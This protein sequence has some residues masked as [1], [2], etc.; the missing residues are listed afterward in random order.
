MLSEGGENPHK[1]GRAAKPPAHSLSPPPLFSQRASVV[2]FLS[3]SAVSLCVEPRPKATRLRRFIRRLH[4]ASC[5]APR[6]C[7][8]TSQAALAS[9]RSGNWVI[10]S[11]GLFSL[12]PPLG[13]VH[14]TTRMCFA[15]GAH[16]LPFHLLLNLLSH[17]LLSCFHFPSV[18]TSTV[19]I[20]ALYILRSLEVQ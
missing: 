15:C 1:A 6:L 10:N 12:A 20:G 19:P 7:I 18:S 16:S 13:G 2:A 3:P 5:I 11:S 17:I 4:E 14:A 9:Y 8:A